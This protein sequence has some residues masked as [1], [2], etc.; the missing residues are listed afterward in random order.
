MLLEPRD[1]SRLKAITETLGA[2][3]VI[4]ISTSRSK[5]VT[6]LVV[7]MEQGN[8]LGNVELLTDGATV[9]NL[10]DDFLTSTKVAEFVSEDVLEVR[11]QDTTVPTLLITEDTVTAITGFPEATQTVLRTT[12]E[13]FLGDAS[14]SFTTWFEN[15]SP[16]RLRKPQYSTLFEEL[17]SRFDEDVLTDFKTGLHTAQDEASPQLRINPVLISLLVAAKHELQFYDISRWGE[18]T[19][20]ASRATY[21]RMKNALEDAALIDNE[22][23]RHQVG[24]PRHQLVLAGALSETTDI[25]VLIA[26]ADSQV[27][28]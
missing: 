11:S 13:S 16:V 2:N 1:D 8:D 9:S 21:S 12:D 20:L 26:S 28:I 22:P 17:E 25:E 23:V 7:A 6:D 19:N 5:A 4:Q 14:D 18:N 10:R 3:D 15:A 24:R 27:S